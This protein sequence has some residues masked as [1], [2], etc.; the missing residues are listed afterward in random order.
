MIVLHLVM[1]EKF[2]DFFARTLKSVSGVTNLYVVYVPDPEQ[3]LN[4]IRQVK[5]FRVVSDSY[6]KSK[7]MHLDLENCDVLVVH[8][9]TP[10][11][12]DMI[13]AAPER[14]KIVWS[15]WGG[16]YYHLLPGDADDLFGSQTRKILADLNFN[17]ARK[18]PIKFARLLL[19]PLRRSYIRHLQLKPA[20]RR[21]NFFSAPLPDDYLILKNHLGSDFSATY[22]QL[23]YGNVHD[24][25]A[26]GGEEVQGSN[27]LVGNSA[28]FTNN[29]IE[30]FNLLKNHDLSNRGVIVP[31]SYGDSAY[32]D[33]ILSSGRKILGDKFHPIVDFL[34]LIEYNKIISTCS[35]AVMN[36]YR[37]QALGNIGSVLYQGAKLFL[38]SKNVTVNFLKSRGAC[39]SDIDELTP[40]GDDPFAPL[41]AHER[42]R[43]RQ[44]LEGFWGANI[45]AENFLNFI[46]KLDT[47]DHCP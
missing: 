26:I 37:Q 47:N 10:F 42:L 40:V 44:V 6:F 1:D 8:F 4:H 3:P 16:D 45:V 29:H 38:N 12:A 35:C 43:N 28:T 39:I 34:P 22:V 15:G 9:L 18:N 5:P 7:T 11:G 25:F 17:I 41:S 19:R 30:V 46:K 36:S 21:V 31:L 27:I 33:I 13:C 14:V 23:N 24:T 2:I 32:R 20:I